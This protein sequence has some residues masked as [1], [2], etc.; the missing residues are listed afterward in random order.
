VN[1][2]A[3]AQEKS[4]ELKPARVAEGGPD[5]EAALKGETPV[6]AQ[7]RSLTAKLYDRSRLLANNVLEGP[8][9]VTEMDSTTLIL[10]GHFGEVDSFGN[11]LVRPKQ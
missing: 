9:I 8:A 1:L 11:I 3:I 4:R 6:W 10:P 7:R 5:P 2:R